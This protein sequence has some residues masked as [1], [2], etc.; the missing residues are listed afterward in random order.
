LQRLWLTKQDYL[1]TG[2]TLTVEEGNVFEQ[3]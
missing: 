2:S 1:E 3:K